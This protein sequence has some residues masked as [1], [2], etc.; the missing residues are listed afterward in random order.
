MTCVIGLEQ[1]GNIFMGGD[2]AVSSGLTVRST[3]I[4][5]VF[6]TIHP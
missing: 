6:R 4:E 1:D 3:M 2:S 5:K